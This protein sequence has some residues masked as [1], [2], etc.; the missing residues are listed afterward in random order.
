MTKRVKKAQQHGEP[1]LG[2][3]SFLDIDPEDDNMGE[4]EAD[5]DVYPLSIKYT[6]KQFWKITIFRY[7]FLFALLYAC[8]PTDVY[9]D[10][11]K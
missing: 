6:T 9:L 1:E 5:E 3:V 7:F 11:R 2:G 4:E 8:I 10:A